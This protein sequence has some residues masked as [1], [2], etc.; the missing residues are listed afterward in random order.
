MCVNFQHVLF[1]Y[2]SQQQ[3][4]END[5]IKKTLKAK[6]EMAKFLQK[7]IQESAIESKKKEGQ[8]AE[9]FA[10]FI[11]TVSLLSCFTF[12]KSSHRFPHLCFRIMSLPDS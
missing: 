10:N 1:D 4:V 3:K 11:D 2:C 12:E 9:S 7:T 5:K 6:I 8:T